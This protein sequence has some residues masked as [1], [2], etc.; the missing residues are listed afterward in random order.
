MV[1]C[2][3]IL[4]LKLT[5][6]GIIEQSLSG[7]STTIKI[8]LSHLLHLAHTQYNILEITSWDTMSCSAELYLL[9]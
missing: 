4:Y 5:K 6:E 3:S 8:M 7:V 2:S 9:S 1:I